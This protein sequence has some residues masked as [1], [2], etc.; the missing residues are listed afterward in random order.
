MKLR[1]LFLLLTI[2]TL[3]VFST[4]VFSEDDLEKVEKELQKTQDEYNE[5]QGDLSSINSKISN[6]NNQINGLS[7]QMNVTQSEINGVLNQITGVTDQI[8]KL[9]DI[10]T[11]FGEVLNQKESERNSTHRTLYKF[12]RQSAIQI[13]LSSVGFLDLAKNSMYYKNYLDQAIGSIR[14]I[15]DEITDYSQ[16]KSDTE[17]ARLELVNQK[18]RLDSIKNNLASKVKSAQTEVEGLQG[19][20]NALEDQLSSLSESLSELTSKQQQLLREKF[21]ASSENLTVGDSESAKQSLP[22]PGFS[23]AYAFVTYG[24]PHRVG[25]S[26]YGAR[27]RANDGQDYKEILDAYYPNTELQEECDADREISVS[28]Y[29]DISLEEYLYGLGEMPSDWP[30]DALKAQAVAARSYALNYTQGGR[31]ICTD[32][33]C[34][35]YIGHAKGGRWNQAVDETC[36]EYLTY[37][38]SPIPAWYA[39]TAGG[40]IRSSGDVWGSSRPYSERLKDWDCSGSL[41]NCAY[42]GPE[43]GDS[44]WFKK[45][46][47]T[48]TERGPWLTETQMEDMFNAYLL[49]EANSDYNSDLSPVDKDG[50]SE[51]E[52][53]EKLEEE[54]ETAV[55]EIDK[56]EVYDDGTGYTTKVRLYSTNYSEGKDF[57]GYMFRS[58]FNLRA[59]GTIVIWTSFFDALT[60]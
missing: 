39:S 21:G 48:G 37:D 59:P 6:I 13:A 32:Q 1:W 20:A 18:A 9:E 60:K 10:L 26:Q 2:C 36:G 17:K 3:V 31:T 55:G 57:D 50:I 30:M 44:P 11:R 42:D 8:V 7:K 22:D 43:F 16:K 56:I 19:Q 45:A 27:G 12:S 15:N 4:P 23:P 58:I 40:F 52:V 34:Q 54:G 53:I 49:S 46:W 5:T 29:G 51:D 14:S 33:R 24:Y 35:V 41:E 28:G 38:G 47:G 25:M